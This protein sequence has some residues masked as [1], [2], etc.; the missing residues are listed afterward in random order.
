M[1]R[2]ERHLRGRD[3][4]GE[5]LWNRQGR[6]QGQVG[7][8]LLEAARRRR[9]HDFTLSAAGARHGHESG[10]S[11]E[12]SKDK[13]RT[14]RSTATGETTLSLASRSLVEFS[15]CQTRRSSTRVR[16]TAPL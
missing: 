16:G 2:E 10:A 5:L 9:L 4:M 14:C 13:N 1:R 12:D 7:I 15:E 8:G 6:V 11:F 3:A